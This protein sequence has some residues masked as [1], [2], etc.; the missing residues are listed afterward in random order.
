LGGFREVIAESKWREVKYRVSTCWPPQSVIDQLDLKPAEYGSS[1][2]ESPPPRPSSR[3][4]EEKI[5]I[6]T[7]SKVRRMYERFL[8]HYE[9][10]T[11]QQTLFKLEKKD[12]IRL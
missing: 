12:K 11:F 8:F 5:G 1:F 7:A 10:L 9:K 6:P 2:D 4:Q 3:E